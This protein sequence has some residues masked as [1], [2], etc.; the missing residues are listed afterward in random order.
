MGTRKFITKTALSL[1]ISK[2]YK[3]VTM[4]DLEKA[5]G[6]TKGAF[7]HH[8]KNKEELFVEVINT[9]Y[10]SNDLFDNKDLLQYGTLKQNFEFLLSKIEE[11]VERLKDFTKKEIVDPYL[12]LLIIE[13]REYYPNFIEKANEKE[14]RQLRKWEQIILRSKENNEV[15][16]DLDTTILCQN[17]IA[18][19]ASLMKSFFKEMPFDYSLSILKLQFDQFYRLIKV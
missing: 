6:L 9:Y 4:S 16:R 1:F 19:E 14:M 8:F 7:Y 3:A 2:S 11:E 12:F 10:L 17:I 15:K 18:I 13:A 5:T